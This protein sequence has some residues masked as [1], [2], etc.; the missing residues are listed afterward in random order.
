M[1]APDTSATAATAKVMD[2]NHVAISVR[3]LDRS[4]E[5]YERGLGMR[6]TLVKPVGKDTWRLIRLPAPASAQSVFLQGEHRIGQIELVQWDFPPPEPSTPKRAGDPGVFALSFKVSKAD[7]APLYERLISMGANCY[8]PP[9]YSWVENYGE[10]G[11]FVCEDPD[12]NQLE[13]VSLPTMEE[14]QANRAAL[15]STKGEI[16]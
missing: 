14:I 6:K 7:I 11:V 2:L 15:K 1:T 10:I 4:V 5:F 16:R 8:D 9:S 13:F 3:D 12:G